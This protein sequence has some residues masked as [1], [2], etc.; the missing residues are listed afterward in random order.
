VADACVLCSD[1]K[2]TIVGCEGGWVGVT[3]ECG[4]CG[5]VSETVSGILVA[6]LR[7]L[8]QRVGSVGLHVVLAVLNVKYVCAVIGAGRGSRAAAAAGAHGLH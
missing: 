2:S 5:T 4:L 8:L 6:D 1:C 7:L 3:V